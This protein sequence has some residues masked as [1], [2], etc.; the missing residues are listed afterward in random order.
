MIPDRQPFRAASSRVSLI[1]MTRVSSNM[2]TM[3]MA[4]NG[5]TIASS[6]A[7]MPRRFARRAAGV[8]F[9]FMV[10]TAFYSI[11][12]VNWAAILFFRNMLVGNQ[13]TSLIGTIA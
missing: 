8:V 9:V 7:A 13:E 1:T 2:P 6:R 5:L 12:M 10:G 4:K 11:R 3:T